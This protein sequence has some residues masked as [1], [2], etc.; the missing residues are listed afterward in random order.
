MVFGHRR[1]RSAL[2]GSRRR[3]S[4]SK[5]RMS[6]NPGVGGSVEEGTRSPPPASK[7]A[8]ARNS[9][10]TW[11]S[12]YLNEF[13]C[14][15]CHKNR[16]D[17]KREVSKIRDEAYQN[18]VVIYTQAGCPYCKKGVAFVKKVGTCGSQLL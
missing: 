15:I 4:S 17:V 7:L 3:S 6:A 5:N 10:F 8:S 13:S 1:S 9:F 12:N 14:G 2:A 11:L 18:R 16:P